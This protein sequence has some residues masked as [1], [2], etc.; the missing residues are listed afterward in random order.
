MDHFHYK[1]GEL[2]AEDAPLSR[3]ADAVGTPF[4]CYSTATIERHF[5]VFA[6]ALK[7]LPATVCYSVKAN[8]NLAVV[9]TLARLGAGADV[10]SGGELTRA[11]AAGIPPNK[12]V[13]SGVGKTEAEISQA[14]TSNILQINVESGP[15]LER[16][17]TVAAS[18]G[19]IAEVAFRIN[20]DV[21]AE[22][23]QKI[24]TGRQ[25]DK[26]GIDW[27]RVHEV[28]TAA[29]GMDNVQPVGLAMHIGSQLTKLDPFR[30]AFN[31]LAQTTA[32]LQ[33]KGFEIK[34]LD[35]GGGLGI[36]YDGGGTPTPADYGKLVAETVG[37]LDC[38]LLFEPGRLIMG[39]AGILVTKVVYVKDG[40]SRRFVIIDAAMNDLIRPAMY[41]AHHEIVPV[42]E[43]R[44]DVGLQPVDV[45]GPVC[46]TGDTFA[47]ELEL[48]PVEQ[49]ELLAIR[50]AGAYGAVM[51]STYNSRALVPEV[52]VKGGE[53]AVVRQRVEIESLLAHE[54]LPN[55]L[56][57]S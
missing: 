31:R 55:W 7:G 27:D 25:E 22:T 47:T 50:S 20:P 21:D 52:L 4:Y 34:R 40:A 29:A 2:A 16:I 35:L 46:E 43:P 37:V 14:L 44:P 48:P 39:N 10:V 19:K 24:S 57:S 56:E 28:F 32:D 9:S 54:S 23:H 8:G 42:S 15:E 13:F 6:D 45:V 26:F 51:S 12:I 53:F 18:L 33:K 1:N 17:N 41:D 3:I 30:N 11:L 36:P 49:S 5:N 38:E